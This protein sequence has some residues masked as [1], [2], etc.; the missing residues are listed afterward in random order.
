[1]RLPKKAAEGTFNP[2]SILKTLTIAVVILLATSCFA[3]VTIT[4]PSN[5]AGV[6]TS[7]H[8]TASATPNRGRT[9]SSMIIYLDGVNSYLKYSNKIDTYVP[10][11]AGIHTIQV[12][13]W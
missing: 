11:K 2:E 4:S 13:S 5:G 7:V 12:K 9:I 1:M 10:L 6:G 3:G 8:V